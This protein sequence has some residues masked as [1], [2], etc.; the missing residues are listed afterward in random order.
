MIPS[1][2]RRSV[3]RK[4][5]TLVELLVAMALILF[6]M[7]IVSV[8]FV[9][10][11]E[12]FRIF[13]A[14]AELSEKLRFITQTLRADLRANHFENNR[15]LSDPD[16]WEVGPPRAGYLRVEQAGAG[17]GTS[18]MDGDTVM[19]AGPNE[20]HVL[21][22]TSFLQGQ[23][24]RGFHSVSDPSLI[25]LRAWLGA[26]GFASDSRLETG[27]SYNSPD[28]EI[29]WFMGNSRPANMP[30]VTQYDF[31]K[32][33]ASFDRLDAGDLGVTLYK[34]YRRV[35][36]MLPCDPASAAEPGFDPTLLSRVSAVPSAIGATIA[37]NKRKF[38]GVSSQ[39]DPNSDVPFRRFFA[40]Y[41]GSNT[42][43]GWRTAGFNSYLATDATTPGA[44]ADY[45][46]IA[47][48]VLSFS[49][50]V[51]PEGATN[52]SSVSAAFGQSV[53]DTW[54]GRPLDG[55]WGVNADFASTNMAGV[56][57]WRDA[58][59]AN[60]VPMTSFLSNGLPK[61]LLAVRITIRLF[62]LN[63]KSTWQA[64]VIEYL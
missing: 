29:A 57:K 55:T 58:A 39:L 45:A 44:A 5:F 48:N 26:N 15:R 43:G 19:T 6:I 11:T 24:Y 36:P 30:A 49:I 13:R 60:R 17:T 23:D 28:A 53:F 22:M 1:F 64:T 18:T 12:S 35:S 59:D 16:F 52:F 50:E 41:I 32:N 7:S 61:R 40:R 14:R 54:C 20:K 37:S 33:S 47:D 10:S 21:M 25:P 9:D 46:V 63:T 51:W 62:D 42:V 34:L 27:N 3:S 8:A 2:D 56:P 31:A 38:N 4:G